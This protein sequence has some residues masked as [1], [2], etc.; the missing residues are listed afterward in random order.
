MHVNTWSDSLPYDPPGHRSVDA[1]RLQGLAAEGPDDFWVGLSRY[2][3]GAEAEMAPTAAD[4]VYVLLEGELELT[5]ETDGVTVV[6]R[7]HDS[8]FL[9][10][11][12]TRRVRNISDTDSLLLVI[13]KPDAPVAR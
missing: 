6:L 2:V 7:R 5:S 10:L 11:G 9:P 8:A 13:L 12:E 3:P 1:R 4:T